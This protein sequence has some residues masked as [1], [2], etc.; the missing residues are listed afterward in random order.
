MSDL[1][2]LQY[3]FPD[4]NFQEIKNATPIGYVIPKEQ[5][6]PVCKFLHENSA[7]YFD[8]LAS[9]SG[10]DNGIDTGTMEVVYHLYSIP[11]NKHL[12]LKAI[13]ERNNPKIETVTSI[14]KSA[15]WHEREAFDL[16]GIEFVG[17]S[18]LRRILLPAD[19]VG[20][21]MRKDYEED[22]TY[23]GMTIKHSDA[24]SEE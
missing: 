14:W 1:P 23:H 3:K 6:L 7:Y 4:I 13:L 8:H 15:D 16:Y 17:H 21:P 24:R 11:F 9:L 19:W 22:K 20:H 2:P 18:D 12:S 5:L 10:V